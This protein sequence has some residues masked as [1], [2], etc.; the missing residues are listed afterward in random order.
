MVLAYRHNTAIQKVSLVK[1]I[2][3]TIKNN[4]RAVS[5]TKGQHFFAALSGILAR[6]LPPDAAAAT[7]TQNE[8]L[9]GSPRYA[10]HFKGEKGL[11]LLIRDS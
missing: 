1:I 4:Y 8:S 5:L 2:A 9:C 11:H 10:Q 6:R 7:F 3:K